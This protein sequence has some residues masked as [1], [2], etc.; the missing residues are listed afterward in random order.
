MPCSHFG[1]EISF[2]NF[3][4]STWL[5]LIASPPVCVLIFAESNSNAQLFLHWWSD[6]ISSFHTNV[7]A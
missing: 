4:N 2:L 6:L 5:E 1:V 7:T 3:Q